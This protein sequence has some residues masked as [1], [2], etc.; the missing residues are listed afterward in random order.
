MSQTVQPSA[1]L[2][3]ID[4]NVDTMTIK[5]GSTSTDLQ[6]KL[7]QVNSEDARVLALQ[8][9]REKGLLNNAIKRHGLRYGDDTTGEV[10]PTPMAAN[11]KPT[12]PFL[13]VELAGAKTGGSGYVGDSVVTR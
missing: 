1:A 13:V 11:G 9:A 4:V 12:N 7:Y 5:V 2:H 3:V 8:A 6:T 10:N